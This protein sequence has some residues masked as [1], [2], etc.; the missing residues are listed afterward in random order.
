MRP[1][2][3]T[4]PRNHEE[5]VE[6]PLAKLQ[7]IIS[8]ALKKLE[9]QKQ[10]IYEL[11]LQLN[12]ASPEQS[13][14]QVFLEGSFE[15]LA[16]EFASYIDTINK[17]DPT[18]GL[19]AEVKP[20]L[21]AKQKD[22]VLKK[23]VVGSMALN[24]APEKEYSAAYN[25]LIYLVMQS[26]NVNMFLPK[27]CENV[28]KPL[29]S[30]PIHGAGL[31]VSVLT[32]LFNFLEEANEVRYNIFQAILRVV[33]TGGLFEMLRP[34]LRMVDQWLI[35][36]DVDEEDQRKL[37]GQIADVAEDA[38]DKEYVNFSHHIC[39]KV[40]IMTQGSL[41]MDFKISTHLHL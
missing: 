9:D 11:S 24:N 6:E 35:L 29:V 8:A 20:L 38:G 40:L 32:I 3:T 4:A 5:P 30:S 39:S 17:V 16:E 36:W 15:D 33:K 2:S 41:P 25:L 28:T 27:L 22:D 18:G 34:Q 1:F 26:P 19:H 10:S 37:Y 12:M 21:E 23:L 31:A 13:K 7:H 14:Q